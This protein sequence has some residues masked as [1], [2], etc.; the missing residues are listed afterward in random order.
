M[1]YDDIIKHYGGM[2][3]AMTELAPHGIYRQVLDNWK[4]TG[5][6]KGR[7]YELFVLSDGA[8]KVDK[9]FL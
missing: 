3:E 2:R 6:P 5:V 8:L 1:T 9:K 4:K 7:Q